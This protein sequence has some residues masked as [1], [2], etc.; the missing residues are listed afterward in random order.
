VE[1]KKKSCRKKPPGSGCEDVKGHARGPTRGG[2]SVGES[3]WKAKWTM[4]KLDP[5]RRSQESFFKRQRGTAKKEKQEGTP[6]RRVHPYPTDLLDRSKRVNFLSKEHT[7][8]KKDWGGG[9]P[10][11]Q[12]TEQKLFTADPPVQTVSGEIWGERIV[13][14]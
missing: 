11:L 12:G 7:R 10:C 6:R 14:K 5:V 2:N 9:E 1:K 4:R 13:K 8:D 3:S